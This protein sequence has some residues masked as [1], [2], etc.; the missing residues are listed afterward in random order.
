MK[1][2]LLAW[3]RI[4][5]IQFYPMT[6]IAYTVGATAV[7]L[8]AQGFNFT[9]YTLGYL[10]LFFL[11]LC[12]ILTNELYDYPTDLINKNASPFNGG[13]RVLVEGGLD[14]REVKAGIVL[15]VC[16]LFGSGVLLIGALERG[17]ILSAVVL[18]VLGV[19]L[20]LGYT[21]PPLKFSYRGLGELVVGITHTFYVMLCGYFFQTGLFD[22]L[23]LWLTSIPLF[24][25]TLAA[26]CLA[27]IPDY[28]ADAT[29]SKKTFA[30]LFG[31]RRSGIASL[32]FATAAWLIDFLLVRFNLV[33]G[34]SPLM[35]LP[36]LLHL[37]ILGIAVLLLL[38]RAAYD[39]R[40][41]GTM[42]L[43]LSYIIW[44]GIIPLISQL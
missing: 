41:D 11:E 35:T 21:V 16:M 29:V 39:R 18:L 33:E 37:V 9:S 13:S 27:G 8:K 1:G 23:S 30:V 4:I 34:R 5:R 10:F 3:V 22:K 25:A 28:R 20:G 2:K 19:L 15:A 7:D 31:Q 42:Q 12:T 26:I 43:A 36:I 6:F 32:V 38:R 44:F 24:F 14:F 17:S 40:I